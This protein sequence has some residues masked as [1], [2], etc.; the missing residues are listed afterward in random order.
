MGTSN[1]SRSSAAA[2]ASVVSAY[3]ARSAATAVDRQIAR[4]ASILHFISISM[5]RT[6]G[7]SNSRAG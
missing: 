2:R 7:K 6:S 3:F 5:R 1:P 4:A